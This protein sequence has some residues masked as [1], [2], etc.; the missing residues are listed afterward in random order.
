MVIVNNKFSQNYK[1][2]ILD[3]DGTLVTNEY[4]GQITERV[5]RT[6][7]KANSTISV[8]IAS[9]R[10]LERVTFVFDELEL[11]T[12]CVIS[13]GTQVVD[14]V[15]H[16]ILWERPILKKDLHEI[17]KVLDKVEYKV[18]VVDGTQEFLYSP[19]DELDNPVNFFLS[20][21]SE[22]EAERLIN[23]L[24]PMEKV[25][26]TK[27][28][29][30][31]PGYVSLHITHKQATKQHAIQK[32][33]ELLSIKNKEIIGV[34]DGYNDYP[35]FKAC[36][37]RVAIGNAVQGLKERADY[38]APSVVDDGVAHVVEKFVFNNYFNNSK[39]PTNLS[40]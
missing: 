7:L 22:N 26:L 3:V 11:K 15:T 40:N 37:L 30:Y 39:L 31:T 6:L 33:A 4:N 16:K 12:P 19:G 38:I 2:I 35:M 36:G 29:A 24:S 34:G 28:V 23:I 9:G 17:R 10:P 8:G 14:P 27:V 5:K 25:T 20:K 1:A 21:I 18:W 32:V 13:G